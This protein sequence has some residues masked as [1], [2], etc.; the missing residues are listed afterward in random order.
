MESIV[1]LKPIKRF[2]E[3]DRIAD[4]LSQCILDVERSYSAFKVRVLTSLR[5]KFIDSRVFGRLQ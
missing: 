3:K 1:R 4:I 5:F 2:L